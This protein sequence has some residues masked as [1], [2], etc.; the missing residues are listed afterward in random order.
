MVLR[1]FSIMIML[2][3]LSF[4]S[5]AATLKVVGG[6]S[7]TSTPEWIAALI[8]DVTSSGQTTEYFCG[9]SLVSSEWL[10]TAA[11]CVDDDF[12]SGSTVTAKAVIGKSDRSTWQSSDYVT[13]D[14]IVTNPNW[15][16]STLT[17]DIA[18]L[19]LASAQSATP[20]TMA[21]S[22]AY[23]SLENDTS[24]LVYGWGSTSSTSTSDTATLSETLQQANV[25][26][27]LD[28][29]DANYNSLSNLYPDDL[30]T[31]DTGTDT[32]YGDSGGPLLYSNILY[33]VTSFGLSDYCGTGLPSG[34]TNLGLF[35][36]WIDQTINNYT[37]TTT[38]SS[39][40]DSSSS[41][42]GGSIDFMLFFILIPV[43]GLRWYQ[44]LRL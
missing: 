5:W 10:V 30:F 32:C 28:T 4:S 39:S 7:V 43:A 15:D 38:N 29:S 21:S 27:Y 33:G 1:R 37:A 22:S 12:P 13:V 2:T 40:D 11:H 31:E 20:V 6:S 16:S 23:E 44:R 26:L 19:H 24:M 36:T 41:G 3:C 25:T 42:G 9:A 14:E 35:R 17:G 34:Y 8:V 18:L